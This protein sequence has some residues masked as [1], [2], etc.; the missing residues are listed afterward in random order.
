MTVYVLSW[1]SKGLFN[2]K[3][4]LL[5]TAF[6]HNIKLSEY[7]MGIKFNKHPLGVEQNNYVTKI[8]NV[9]IVYDLDGWP[10]IS[11]RNFTMKTCL[12]GATSIVKNSDKKV[13]V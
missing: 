1:K 8:L 11:H 3:L 4:K 9:C 2:S 10:K 6:L 5:Y 12:F 13:S 7:R